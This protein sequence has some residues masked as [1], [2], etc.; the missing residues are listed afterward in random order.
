MSSASKIEWTNSTFNPVTG[1]SKVSAGCTN[2][3][4]ERMARR[5]Q[6]MGAPKYRNGF[7]V[8]LHP[9]ILDQVRTWRKPRLVFVNSMSDLFHE[10]VPVDFI[11]R[12]FDVMMSVPQ[13]VFQI[14]TKRSERLARLS[15]RLPWPDN[16][17]MGVTVESKR[18]YHRIDDLHGCGAYGK[19]L[20]LEPLLGPLPE[21]NLTGIDWVIVGGESGPGARPM[22]RAWVVD[23]RKQCK[24]QDVAFFFKQWGGVNKKQSGR[25]LDGRIYDEVPAKLFRHDPQGTLAL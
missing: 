2:C 18:F 22:D 23:I 12:L 7:E 15:P 8:T 4:A 14:L 25:L 1:C 16:V 24:A 9:E 17:W 20:S 19:F 10:E 3:Y 13:H 6:A 5:L 11:R 21:L